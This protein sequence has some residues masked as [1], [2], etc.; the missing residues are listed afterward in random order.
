FFYVLVLAPSLLIERTRLAFGPD[1][2]QIYRDY[3]RSI[4][5]NTVNFAVYD[6]DKL[7]NYPYQ[8][9]ILGASPP[10]RCFLTTPLMDGLKG[11][12]VHNLGIMGANI[13]E[14]AEMLDLVLS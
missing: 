1:D 11:Y 7:D 12:K 5:A 10:G 13:T 8:V 3:S 6:L 4:Y 2:I 9:I 14:T